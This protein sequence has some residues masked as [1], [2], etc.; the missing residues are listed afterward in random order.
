LPGVEYTSRENIVQ[1]VENIY[2]DQEL[3]QDR[4]CKDFLQVQ[5]EGARQVKRK[6]TYYNLDMILSVGYRVRSKTATQFRQW[7]T[8][9]L[10][11]HLVLGYTINQQRLDQLNQVLSIASRALEPPGGERP[12][13]RA[14]DEYVN[15]LIEKM[16]EGK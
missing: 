11:D 1:H 6:R 8:R 5:M 15:S 3:L 9:V 7:A 14:G 16:S 4:T 2:V 13:V 12:D 10:N